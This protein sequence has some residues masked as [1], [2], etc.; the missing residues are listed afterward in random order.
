[1]SAIGCLRPS[2]SPITESRT[3]KH[4]RTVPT[5]YSKIHP[6]LSYH[7]KTCQTS[8]DH[9]SCQESPPADRPACPPSSLRSKAVTPVR[10][11]NSS[12]LS[13]SG[14]GIGYPVD[15]DCL[16]PFIIVKC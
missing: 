12:T 9:N 4:T 13:L 1:M 15:T 6:L 5:E 11:L 2:I 7:P 3:H 10:T 8:L 14:L 16:L